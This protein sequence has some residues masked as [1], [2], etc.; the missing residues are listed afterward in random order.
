MGSHPHLQ[1][2][3]FFLKS[4]IPILSEVKA[5]LHLT[6]SINPV[7]REW[8]RESSAETQDKNFSLLKCG[9]LFLKGSVIIGV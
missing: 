6:K 5:M 4:H 8:V 2:R 1:R 9:V 7:S 3:K